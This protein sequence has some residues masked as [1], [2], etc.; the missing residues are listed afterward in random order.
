L[1]HAALA[2]SG[3]STFCAARW[4]R[5]SCRLPVGFQ[6]TNATTVASAFPLVQERR[7]VARR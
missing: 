4:G 7:R 1:G 2:A 5:R 6:P 3:V